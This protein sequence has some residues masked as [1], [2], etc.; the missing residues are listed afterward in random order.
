MMTAA[1]AIGAVNFLTSS[2]KISHW[3]M[4]HFSQN[5]SWQSRENYTASSVFRPLIRG[6][7]QSK[8][9]SNSGSRW[10][11]MIRGTDWHQNHRKK[12]K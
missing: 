3:F 6:Y 8:A 11:M 9:S 7:N 10:K 5:K 4:K 2:F 1:N 12:A